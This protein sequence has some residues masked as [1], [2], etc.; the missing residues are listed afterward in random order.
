MLEVGSMDINGT[1]REFFR[2]TGL[3][4]TP[5]PRVDVVCGGQEYA[6]P[7]RSFDVVLSCEAME[8]NPDRVQTS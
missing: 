5:G 6:A 3:D 8:H 4:V 1:I 7:D 2:D